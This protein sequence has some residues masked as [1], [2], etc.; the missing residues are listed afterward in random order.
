MM[1]QHH[2]YRALYQVAAGQL[3]YLSMS[4][5]RYSFDG[6]AEHH[7]KIADER[8]IAITRR[9]SPKYHDYYQIIAASDVHENHRLREKLA[10]IDTMKFIAVCRPSRHFLASAEAPV[11]HSKVSM[12]RRIVNA[13]RILPEGAD[14][15]GMSH[16]HVAPEV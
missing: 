16:E 3:L 7:K 8:G 11:R 6:T 5:C 2:K 12:S 9:V 15:G 13:Y 10:I 4:P 1:R 14:A